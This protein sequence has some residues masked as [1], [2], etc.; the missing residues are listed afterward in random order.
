V[1]RNGETAAILAGGLGTR[2][3]HALPGVPKALA[4]VAG[5]PF[6][7]RLLRWLEAEGVARALLLCGHLAPAMEAFV[8]DWNARSGVPVLEISVEPA[9][10]GTGGAVGLAAARLPQDFFLLNGDTLCPVR[11]A[12]LAA[13]HLAARAAVTLTAVQQRERAARGA[14][15]LDPH[16]RV[17]GFAEKSREGAGWI[18][19]GVYRVRRALFE[20]LPAGRAVSLEH[21]LLPEWISRGLTVRALRATAPFLDIGTPA[22]WARAQHEGWLP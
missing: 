8:R 13:V 5:E 2:L 21:D 6:L 14:L 20:G 17:L 4:P 9:P 19:A 11:L 16:N 18:N 15:E 1:N 22:D 10:L 3:S 7:S 12:D